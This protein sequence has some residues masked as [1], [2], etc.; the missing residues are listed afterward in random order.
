[1]RQRASERFGSTDIEFRTTNMDDGAGRV[2]RVVG[3]MVVRRGDVGAGEAHRF[4]CSVDETGRVRSA[5]VDESGNRGYQEGN[6]QRSRSSDSGGALNPR[7]LRSCKR[8]VEERL[9]GDGYGSVEFETI[10]VDN[11]G[12]AG[13]VGT[14]RADGDQGG[15]LFTFSCSMETDGRTVQSIDVRRR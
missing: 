12:G 13:L 8:A 4:S 15:Q 1:V 5:R 3:T 6:G 2:N 14:A 11:R 10:R 7:A 9:Q